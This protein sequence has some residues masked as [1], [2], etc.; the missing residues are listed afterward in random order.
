MIYSHLLR[1]CDEFTTHILAFTTLSLM[2]YSQLLYTYSQLLHSCNAFTAQITRIYYTQPHHILAFTTL[3]EIT[4]IHLNFGLVLPQFILGKAVSGGTECCRYVSIRQRSCMG[5]L[6]L[7]QSAKIIFAIRKDCATAKI[8]FAIRR[9][10][11]APDSLRIAIRG[12]D[13]IGKLCRLA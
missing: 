12:E 7:L 10:C 11:V 4:A 9:G 13:A 3:I 5:V 2:T 6:Y 8:I 1:S